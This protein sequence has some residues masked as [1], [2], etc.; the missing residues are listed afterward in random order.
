MPRVPLPAELAEFWQSYSTANLFRDVVDGQWG[1]V[2]FDFDTSERETAA[3]RE[4]FFREEL[5]G[6]RIAGR[7]IGDSDQLMVRCDPSS[8]DY[9]K[10]IVVI[11]GFRSEWYVA[12]DDLAS[13][14]ALYEKCEGQKY[15]E[16][17]FN[18]SQNDFT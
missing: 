18:A 8:S 14:L 13:F 9:G 17:Q 11:D 15:W 12:A 4:R 3:Y 6:D 16:S 1:L 10:V 5:P 7:F 2:L